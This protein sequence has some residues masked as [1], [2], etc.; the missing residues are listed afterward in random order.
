M[1]GKYGSTVKVVGRCMWL[2]EGGVSGGLGA[3]PRNIPMWAQGGFM[4]VTL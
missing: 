2:E 1:A 4:W 3:L